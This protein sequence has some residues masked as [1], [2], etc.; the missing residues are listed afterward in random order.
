M[1]AR[2]DSA[3][4][5]KLASGVL[6]RKRKV[7]RKRLPI[8]SPSSSDSDENVDEPLEVPVGGDE[9]EQETVGDTA[10]ETESEYPG[11]EEVTVEEMPVFKREIMC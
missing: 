2:R 1:A 7:P 10:S 5:S 3:K 4:I 6:E 8:D 9:H 11:L